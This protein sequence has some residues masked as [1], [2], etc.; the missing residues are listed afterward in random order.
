MK[1]K[2]ASKNRKSTTTRKARRNPPVKLP[3]KGMVTSRHDPESSSKGGNELNETHPLPFVLFG[4]PD[5][6]NLL[7]TLYESFLRRGDM[8]GYELVRQ[9]CDRAR[10]TGVATELVEEWSNRLQQEHM[11]KVRAEGEKL[12]RE[13]GKLLDEL[14]DPDRLAE[15]AIQV[16][17]WTEMQ[18]AAPVSTGALGWERFEI[19]GHD[20][21]PVRL[22][23]RGSDEIRRLAQ[24]SYVLKE[25]IQ[26][27][28]ESQRWRERM[29]FFR[30]LIQTPPPPT[31]LLNLKG[32]IKR[33]S[34]PPLSKRKAEYAELL[35]RAKTSYHDLKDIEI[36]DPTLKAEGPEMK[37]RLLKQEFPELADT[38]NVDLPP[39]RQYAKIAKLVLAKR[40]G[41]TPS[42]VATRLKR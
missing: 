42:T 32:R 25:A 37:Y 27:Y 19:I 41:V 3:Q 13:K 22:L 35:A 18:R 24:R 30:Q 33:E 2:P 17:L 26:T 10:R 7:E 16:M 1:Q 20:G 15:K 4:P 11:T 14:M 29:Q 38:S 5:I 6:H 12:D 36:F 8:M 34:L 28:L 23:P 31:L 9:L 39:L 21:K 40:W